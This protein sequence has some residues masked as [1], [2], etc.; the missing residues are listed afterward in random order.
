[1]AQAP[2]GIAV[3]RL[4][5]LVR[6]ALRNPANELV[7]F[8]LQQA[9]SQIDESYQPTPG[10]CW[11]GS[12][13]LQVSGIFGSFTLWR[14]Y[15]YN[16]SSQQGHH[17]VDAILG[18]EGACTPALARLVCYEGAEGESFQT[19]QEHLLETGAIEVDPR[20]IQ[21]IIQAMGPSARSWSQREA[22]PE[23]CDA[24]VMYV[25]A[26]ATGIPMRKSVLAGRKGKQPDG[27]AKTQAANLGCVFTQHTRDAKGHP[28]RDYNST[29]YIGGM[30]R[31]EDLGL[32]LRREARRRGSGTAKEIVVLIDGAASLEHLGRINFPG[33]LQIVDFYH[34]M[35]HLAL[36]TDALLGKNHPDHKTQYNR[37]TKLLLKNG[38]EKII[39]EARQQSEG[40]ANAA[41]V[42]SALGYFVRN[43]ARMQYGTFRQKGYFIG[44]GVIEAGCKTLVGKRCKQSGMF[45]SEPGA[46][47]IIA[48]RCMIRSRQWDSFWKYRANNLAATVNCLPLAA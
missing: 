15:Y 26:D 10:E 17:P 2:D 33:C 39:E 46:S 22:K 19:A 16:P 11:K 12:F 9:A 18:L 31:V 4:E 21:R 44:S 27:T 7:G 5:L 47:N 29:T 30:D 41:A 8:L 25:S 36:L 13:P 28:I 48:M 24:K 37:W 14:H 40:K 45:W 42:E 35:E 38:V 1:M 43:V 23:P 6:T 20:Q 34:A 3:Q 32:T